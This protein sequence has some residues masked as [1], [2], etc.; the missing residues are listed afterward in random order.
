M[1][2]GSL[3]RHDT[4]A[5][6]PWVWGLCSLDSGPGVGGA[7]VD[8]FRCARHSAGTLC[9]WTGHATGQR[10]ISPWG[11]LTLGLPSGM[12]GWH[13]ERQ[14][15]RHQMGGQHAGVVDDADCVAAVHVGHLEAVF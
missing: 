1:N 4:V 6:G 14:A 10:P 13:A 7:N 15:E 11:S 3:K 2:G 12:D 9:V 8:G 5:K